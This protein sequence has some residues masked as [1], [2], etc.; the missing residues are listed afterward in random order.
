MQSEKARLVLAGARTVFLANGFSAATTDMIQQAAGVSKST[1]YSHYPNKEALFVAV[2]EAECERFL[3]AVRK[4]KFPE[5]RLADI[6]NAMALAYLEIVLSRDGLALYRMIAAEAPRFPELG[7][8]FYLAGP[9]AINNIVAETLEVAASKGELDLGSIGF[10]SAASLF[11]NMVRG[12][13]QMQC[14]MHPDA[15]ASA[16]QRDRWAKD[17][18]TTFLRAFQKNN[19]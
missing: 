16:A 2:V 7:R 14:V 1:V 18:V 6:L 17:A 11:V 19:G 13:A 3:R 4:P 8:R 9:A 12:E 5:E 15:P 10:D